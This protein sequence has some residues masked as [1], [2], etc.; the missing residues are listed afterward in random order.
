[1]GYVVNTLDGVVYPYC[2]PVGGPRPR[3]GP[4]RGRRV[5]QGW[6]PRRQGA[7]LRIATSE[8]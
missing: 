3:C 4:R 5:D 7:D 6:N 1:M 8:A 2:R